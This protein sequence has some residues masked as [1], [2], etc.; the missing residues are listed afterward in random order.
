M[1]PGMG[2]G[3]SALGHVGEQFDDEIVKLFNEKALNMK[4]KICEKGKNE[5][6][7]GGDST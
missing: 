5:L 4:T 1:S 6:K 2:N 3:K 7:E